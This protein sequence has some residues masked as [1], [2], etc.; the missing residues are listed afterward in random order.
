MSLRILCAPGVQNGAA[1]FYLVNKML[2]MKLRLL[3]VED[4]KK[5]SQGMVF[6]KIFSIP[7]KPE[8]GMS[9]TAMGSYSF[10]L[11]YECQNENQVHDFWFDLDDQC[12]VVNLCDSCSNINESA[13]ELRKVDW[14]G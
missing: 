2:K 6:E 5:R 11:G 4:G 3:L 14:I 8:V 10:T 1:V 13:E 12:F 7:F 9:F